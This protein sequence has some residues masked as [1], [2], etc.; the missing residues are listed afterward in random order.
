MYFLNSMIPGFRAVK[1]YNVGD[2][3][4]FQMKDKDQMCLNT[5]FDQFGAFLQVLQPIFS[6]WAIMAHTRVI[7]SF[8][9]SCGIGLKNLHRALFMIWKIIVDLFHCFMRK[10]WSIITS[11]STITSRLKRLFISSLPW[12]EFF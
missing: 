10:L 3:F 8:Q 9:N 5:S 2:C 4:W 1:I 6:L 12:L 7:T 11:T